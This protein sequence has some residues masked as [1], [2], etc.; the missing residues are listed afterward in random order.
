RYKEFSNF[1]SSLDIPYFNSFNSPSTIRLISFY[2]KNTNY[3]RVQFIERDDKNNVGWVDEN[4]IKSKADCKK[5]GILLSD[6][7]INSNDPLGELFYN[8]DV[9]PKDPIK[10][11]S[12]LDDKNCCVFPLKRSPKESYTDGIKKFGSSRDKGSRTH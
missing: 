5:S 6:Y 8:Q 10:P 3:I 1:P 7:I 4:L 11:I 12:G 9:K 2:G